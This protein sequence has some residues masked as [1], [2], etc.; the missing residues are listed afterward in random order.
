VN[1][2]RLACCTPTVFSPT[3]NHL[4]HARDCEKHSQSLTKAELEIWHAK[5]RHPAHHRPIVRF[6]VIDRTPPKY[7]DSDPEWREIDDDGFDREW[8]GE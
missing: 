1:G 5:A 6:R 8:V 4:I 3:S 2:P 7:E